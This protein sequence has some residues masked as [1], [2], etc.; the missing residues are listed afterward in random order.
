MSKSVNV[1]E[2][3]LYPS[4]IFP[5][6]NRIQILHPSQSE[7]IVTIRAV[8]L[9]ATPHLQWKIFLTTTTDCY[10]L[11]Y[12]RQWRSSIWVTRE[13]GFVRVHWVY[14]ILAYLYMHMYVCIYMHIY[15][16]VGRKQPVKIK[17]RHLCWRNFL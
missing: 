8:Q 17:W 16:C 11:Q 14:N 1:S 10:Q 9:L 7:F 3:C 5:L 2:F 4:H 13:K 12:L 15:M 6:H